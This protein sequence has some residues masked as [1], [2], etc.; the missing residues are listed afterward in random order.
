MTF[1]ATPLPPWAIALVMAAL[2]PMLTRAGARA[3]ERH[4]RARSASA[5]ASAERALAP[6]GGHRA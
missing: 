2:T 4:A 1:G 3:L 5:L 6:S